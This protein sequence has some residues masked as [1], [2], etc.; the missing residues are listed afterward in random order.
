MQPFRSDV[1]TAAALIAAASFIVAAHVASAGESYPSRPV[2][3]IAAFS[4]GG[5]VDFTA[6]LVAA[7]LGAALGQPFIVENR[8]GAGGIVGT[9][10][11]ARAA[12]DGHT[13]V[14]GSVGTHAV[15]QSLYPKLPYH[16]LRDFLPI[17]R[18][19]DA[20]SILAVHPSLPARSVKE[21]IALAR[22]RS[23]QINY[24]SAGA[25][26]STHLAAVLF[27]H[28][29]RIRLVHVPYKGGGPALVAVVAGEVPVTF[30]TAASVSPHTKS[31]R[32]RALAV[33]SGQRSAV[34]TDV[35][36]IAEAGLPGYEM[37]NWLGLFAPA[38][39]PRAIVQRLSS[40]AVKIVRQPEVVSRFHAQA[41]E[42]SP[43]AS[44]EFAAFVKK[45]VDKW[46]KV[47]AATGMTTE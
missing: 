37:L 7:P 41:S 8:A 9:E 28:M 45:E 40:E 30:G 6:R 14:V 15:N 46:A 17:A 31:G 21:L 44:D 12:P 47:V 27:E 43:L 13:L 16:V 1:R 34:L 32:L 33:T 22:A 38:G 10:V 29:A 36:T 2:R 25:G 5:Y 26:T 3:V 18:L 24:A 4:P 19:S 11:V 42:P 35:P 39:T 23:G 20:P